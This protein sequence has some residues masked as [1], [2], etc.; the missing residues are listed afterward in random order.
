MK[1]DSKLLSK[2]KSVATQQAELT[3]YHLHTEQL[4]NLGHYSV[5]AMKFFPPTASH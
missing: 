4:G 1:N 5:L 2:P 3:E